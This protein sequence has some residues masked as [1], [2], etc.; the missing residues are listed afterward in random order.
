MMMEPSALAPLLTRRLLHAKVLPKAR[1][2]EASLMLIILKL[3]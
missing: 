1:A 2:S 3:R